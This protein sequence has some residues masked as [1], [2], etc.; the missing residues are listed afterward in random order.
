VC[1]PSL[2]DDFF[3]PPPFN[4]CFFF[5]FVFF[6]LVSDLLRKPGLSVPFFPSL[7][8]LAMIFPGV[9]PPSPPQRHRGFQKVRVPLRRETLPLFFFFPLSLFFLRH[10]VQSHN[11]SRPHPS[12]SISAI[13]VALRMGQ[14]LDG[15]PTPLFL[16]FLS[17][18]NR[19]LFETTPPFTPVGGVSPCSRSSIRSV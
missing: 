11:P 3:S 4:F 15:M 16:F 19:F 8:P 10:S 5:F 9:F 12:L 17:P 14:S 1:S 2:Q 13:H 6:F 7:L 18:I